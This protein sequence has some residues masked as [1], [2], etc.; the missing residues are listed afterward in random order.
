MYNQITSD[1][2]QALYNINQKISKTNDLDVYKFNGEITQNDINTYCVEQQRKIKFDK[3]NNLAFNVYLWN[4]SF[5]SSYGFPNNKLGFNGQWMEH[6]M[7]PIAQ[8]LSGIDLNENIHIC[9]REITD[10]DEQSLN[11]LCDNL[12][13]GNRTPETLYKDRK[14]SGN[15]EDNIHTYN[16]YVKKILSSSVENNCDKMSFELFNYEYYCIEQNP[17]QYICPSYNEFYLNH[18][19]A[20]ND[21]NICLTISNYSDIEKNLQYIYDCS[22]YLYNKENLKNFDSDCEKWI[23]LIN[24]LKQLFDTIGHDKP[25][26]TAFLPENISKFNEVRVLTNCGNFLDIVA[27]SDKYF[28]LMQYTL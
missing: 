9:Y 17:I 11:Y 20:R 26:W 4:I 25:F 24:K 19:D 5:A 14:T 13:M 16:S 2:E 21:N 6:K 12:C 15:N 18:N 23:K 8:Y 28:Y 22:S 27:R 1:I 7:T 10:L 3:N